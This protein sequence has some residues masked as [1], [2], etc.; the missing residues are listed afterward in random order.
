MRVTHSEW[1]LPSDGLTFY[2]SFHYTGNL[3]LNETTSSSHA[4]IR[5]IF[6]RELL[7]S[8]SGSQIDCDAS[9][10]CSLFPF[11]TLQQVSHMHTTAL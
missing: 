6:L 9:S 5:V 3:S 10:P 7:P 4:K 11:Q 2:L 8:Q 1:V